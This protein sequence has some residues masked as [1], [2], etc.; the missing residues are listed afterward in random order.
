MI[1]MHRFDGSYPISGDGRRVFGKKSVKLDLILC[2][3]SEK[4]F[5]M[6][7]GSMRK[8]A[9]RPDTQRQ[10]GNLDLWRSPGTEKNVRSLFTAQCI[11]LK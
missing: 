6:H 3:P 10:S 1:R 7:D 5:V 4:P 2:K 11:A 9:V 8:I